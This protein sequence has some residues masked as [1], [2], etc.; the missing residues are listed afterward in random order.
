[1]SAHRNRFFLPVLAGLMLAGPALAQ[2]T[3]SAPA[4]APGTATTSTAP[5]QNTPTP[6]DAD[7]SFLT[8]LRRVGVMAGEVVQC[9]ADAD[10]QAQISQ[11]MELANQIAIH[12]GLRAAFNFVG[13]LGYG[14]G[15]PFDKAGCTQ[16]LEGWKQIQAKYL[17]K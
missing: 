9:A 4:P 2:N 16:A 10:K 12:F 3:P 11:A 7:P 6:P 15:R 14:S 8:G 1:M 5:A 17:N 13:A